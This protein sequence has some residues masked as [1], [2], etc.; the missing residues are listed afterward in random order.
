MTQGVLELGVNHETSSDRYAV[1]PI[2]NNVEVEVRYP[3]C[4][5]P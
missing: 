1:D 4:K 2:V 3:V 5:A